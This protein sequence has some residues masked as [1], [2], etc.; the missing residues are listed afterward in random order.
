M[1]AVARLELRINPDQKRLIEEAAAVEHQSVTAFVVDT[2]VRRA[3]AVVSGR[4]GHAPRPVGG[5]SFTL[6][7]GWDEPLDDFADWR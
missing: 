4:E 1:A 3:R 5:W 2:L 7:E 6:P